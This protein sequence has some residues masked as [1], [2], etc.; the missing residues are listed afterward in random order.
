MFKNDD[1][2]DDEFFVFF[3]SGIDLIMF[4]EFED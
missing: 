3:F 2:N 1:D 4:S